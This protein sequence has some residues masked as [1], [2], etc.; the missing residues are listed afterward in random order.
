MLFLIVASLFV[1]AAESVKRDTREH[2]TNAGVVWRDL[3]GSASKGSRG[4]SDDSLIFDD[5]I[6]N[7][8]LEGNFSAIGESNYWSNEPT[9]DLQGTL[10]AKNSGTC[11]VIAEATETLPTLLCTVFHKWTDGSLV[12]SSLMAQGILA[13]EDGT[14][15][16]ELP[17]TGGSG[18]FAG[19]AGLLRWTL[20]QGI[21]NTF[22]ASIHLE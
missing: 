16:G 18:C 15:Y 6:N 8:R 2:R 22:R 4:C 20:L 11:T 1:S 13:E 17:L 3:K 7:D 12:D 9:I 14:L 19:A 5:I 21:E 10:V